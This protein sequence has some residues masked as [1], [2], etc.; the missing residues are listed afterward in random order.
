MKCSLPL[1]PMLTKTNR[2]PKNFNFQKFKNP[3]RSLMMTIRKKLQNKR[4]KD[5]GALLDSC[6]WSDIGNFLQTCIKNSLLQTKS[7]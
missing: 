3:K 4:S 1:G 2:L 6:S 7:I 5:L